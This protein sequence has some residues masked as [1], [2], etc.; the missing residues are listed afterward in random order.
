M[1]AMNK[2][3]IKPNQ[4]NNVKQYYIDKFNDVTV[5][6]ESI[7]GKDKPLPESAFLWLTTREQALI[8]SGKEQVLIQ[9]QDWNTLNDTLKNWVQR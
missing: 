4:T 3:N 8:D 1:V 7:V 5:S 9:L 6:L 2:I